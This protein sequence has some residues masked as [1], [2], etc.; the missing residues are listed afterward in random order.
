MRAF[1]PRPPPTVG[2]LVAATDLAAGRPLTPADLRLARLPPSARPRG[3][4]D[5]S[6]AVGR[7]LASP[8]RAGEPLTDVRL[9]GPR[10]VDALGPGLV[11][12]PVRLADAASV[13]LIAPGDL[14]DLLAAPVDPGGRP[15]VVAL[16]VRV[17]S[18]PSPAA[19]D[20]AGDGALVVVAASRQVALAV[21][22]AA[23]VDRLSVSL[24]PG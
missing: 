16:A 24:L 22:G 21:A 5:A 11:A 9:V 7:L 1:A 23:T 3:S 8:L 13:S 6:S 15:A 14:V 17:L 20:A 18:V 12:V 10:L 4:V 19:G 2:V